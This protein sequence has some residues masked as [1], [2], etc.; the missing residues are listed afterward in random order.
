MTVFVRKGKDKSK[1]GESI[2]SF[3]MRIG[4][5]LRVAGIIRDN[6]I[7]QSGKQLRRE[8][9]LIGAV[10]R[11]ARTFSY[12]GGRKG[13]GFCNGSSSCDDQ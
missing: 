10:C 8:F 4:S 12:S 2:L 9:L 11:N 5:F 6:K 13:G 7:P 1:A 3:L